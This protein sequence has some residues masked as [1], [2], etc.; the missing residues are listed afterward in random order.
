MTQ[1]LEAP[2]LHIGTKRPRVKDPILLTVWWGLLQFEITPFKAIDVNLFL[3]ET[4]HPLSSQQI[5]RQLARLTD[6]GYLI[7]ERNGLVYE[8]SFTDEFYAYQQEA[9]A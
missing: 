1:T 7:R 6:A 5:G 2:P 4:E 8:Y 3:Q 9:M